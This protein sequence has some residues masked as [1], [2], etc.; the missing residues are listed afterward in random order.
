MQHIVLMEL[1]RN[2]HI[3][4]LYFIALIPFIVITQNVEAGQYID[5]QLIR[6]AVKEF[7]LDKTHELKYPDT[8][9]DV[10]KI[11]NRLKLSSCNKDLELELGNSRIPGNVSVAVRCNSTKPWKIYLQATVKAFQSIYVSQRPIAK[12]MPIRSSDIV[13]A[14]RNI[15][16]LNDDY[17]TDISEIEGHIAKRSIRKNEVIKP[18]YLLKSKLIKRGEQVT[19]I[20]ETSGISVRMKGKAMNDATTGERVKV[21]NN[22]S[23]RIIEGTAIKHGVV[24]I[25]M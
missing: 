11:D 1:M 17:L 22:N 18:F 3:L 15:T 16:A 23:K 6:V 19:I 21:K 10:G 8:Q 7:L 4:F 20:A 24:K 9:I 25:N 14:R 12:G 13:L 2:K 5:H